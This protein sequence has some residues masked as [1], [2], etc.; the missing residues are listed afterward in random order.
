MR[1]WESRAIRIARLTA[2]LRTKYQWL[3]M[4]GT[5]SGY[6]RRTKLLKKSIKQ[7]ARSGE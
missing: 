4:G 6:N 1:V 3:A 2:H 5:E 7:I